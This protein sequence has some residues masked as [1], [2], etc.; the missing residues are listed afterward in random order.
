MRDPA[1][2]QGLIGFGIACI[3]ECHPAIARFGKGLHHAGIQAAR[4]HLTNK[5]GIR[6][7]RQVSALEF[8]SEEIR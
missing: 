2:K 1:R 6:F 4:F 5:A 3:F 7:Q 8:F